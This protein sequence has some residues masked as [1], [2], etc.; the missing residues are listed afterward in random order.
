[1][2]DED[3]DDVLREEQDRALDEHLANQQRSDA[4]MAPQFGDPQSGVEETNTLME[5]D[6]SVR[7]SARLRAQQ[8][9]AGPSVPAGEGQGAAMDDDAESDDLNLSSEDEQDE[10][11][12][13]ANIRQSNARRRAQSSDGGS[14]GGDEAGADANNDDDDGASST[15]THRL[16]QGLRQIPGWG[17]LIM[18]DGITAVPP[19]FSTGLPGY[20]VQFSNTGPFPDGVKCRPVR[21][22]D[23]GF[24]GSWQQA[25]DAERVCDMAAQTEKVAKARTVATCALMGLLSVGMAKGFVASPNHSELAEA[26]RQDPEEGGSKAER[27]LNGNVKTYTYCPNATDGDASLAHETA[28]MFSFVHIAV[29]NSSGR[30]VG[31]KILM[32]IFDKGFS[33]DDLVNKVMKE[34]ALIKKSGQINGMPEEQRNS[35]MVQQNISQR[36][37]LD[38][39]NLEATA[40]MQY[41][42]ICCNHDYLKF[43]KNVGG[44]GAGQR[45]RPYYENIAR[46]TPPG[47]AMHDFA[48]CPENEYGGRHPIGPTIS[49]NHKRYVPPTENSPGVNVFTA[50]TLDA[51]GKPI[52]LHESLIDPR[53]WY[54]DYGNFDPPQHVKDSGWCHIC[55]DPSVTNIMSAPLP[56]KMHGNVEP[57][58][59]LLRIFWDQNKNSN[60]ILVKARERGHVTFEQNRDAVLALFHR[61]ED[62]M[63]P[64]QQNLARAVL[65]TEMLSNDSLNKT[66]AEEASLERRAYGKASTN[67]GEKWVLSVRQPLRDIS[68]EQEKVHAMVNDDDKRAR[69]EISKQ[70]Y[71]VGHGQPIEYD[72]M[73]ARRERRERHTEATRATIKL[74]LQRFQHT[75][76][77]AKCVKL[78]PPGYYDVAKVGLEAAVKE[79]G[80][81]GKRRA[82]GGRNLGRKVDPDDPNALIGT[83]NIGFAHA[84]SLVAT[85]LTPFGHHRAFLMRLFSS[86]VNIAGRDVKLMLECHV[87]AF[88]PFQEVSFFLLLCGGP[89]SGK[90]MRAKRMMEL[91][92]DG[93][94]HRSGDGSAKAGMNGGFDHLCGRLVYYD[95]GSPFL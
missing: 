38:D 18:G 45:G 81:I 10:Q 69:V 87:H 44:E 37:Q 12:E 83:A 67:E 77:R 30:Y 68:I 27:K 86:G 25:S 65:E 28:M 5:V 32:L 22:I 11:D 74:G 21:V 79:A 91:L 3:M 62:T 72:V 34:N 92:P 35:R 13:F 82:E 2:D 15:Y 47:C 42:R 40:V 51:R 52:D 50:G 49:H 20:W 7:G 64:E 48:K 88:E 70:D 23:L 57:E 4:E 59:C 75:F 1:M 33:L 16:R 31:F 80:E 78:I 17:P 53:D 54:D 66:A 93:W 55:H 89:G 60:P 61:M 26:R 76:G 8:S 24:V 84:Q 14:G 19:L 58:D 36:S 94:V 46:D 9:R 63:D 6:G 95:G 90:S 71:D 85:D 56:H 29:H 43:L 73:G 39:N 41:R